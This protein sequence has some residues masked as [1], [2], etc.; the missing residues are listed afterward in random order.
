MPSV[1]KRTRSFW[2][3]GALIMLAGLALRLWQLGRASLWYDEVITELYAQASWDR[4]FTQVLEIGNHTPLYFILMRFFPTDNEFWLR[5]PSVMLGVIGVALLIYCS[6]RLYADER[7]ALLAGGLLAFNPY[8][9][10]LSRTARPYPL[11]FVFSLLASYYF[12][13]LLRGERTR[14]NWIAFTLCSMIAYVTHYFAVGLP[15]AQYVLFA[16]ILRG[17]RGFFR[18]WLWAQVIAGIPLL[19]WIIALLQQDQVAFGIG[20]IPRPRVTAIPV[21][22]WN[23][24]LGYDGSFPWYLPVGLAAAAVGL[25]YGIMLAVRERKKDRQN[26]YWFWLLV[27]PLS[28]GFVVSIIRPLYVDRYFTVFLPSVILL[29]AHGWN[30]LPLRLY[31]RIG[32]AVVVMVV[33][34]VSVVTTLEREDDEKEDWR[35]AAAFIESEQ[36]PEDALLLE[37]PIVILLV[38]RYWDTG[39]M[40][41]TWLE[42]GSLVV[43]QFKTPV[44]RV[45]ALYRNP[46]EDGHQQG[47]LP[48]F[49]PFEPSNSPLSDWLIAR[50]D[51]VIMQK[52]LNGIT[53]LLVDMSGELAG[54]AN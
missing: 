54:A 13:L 6:V 37:E 52:E 27:A 46:N 2:W 41:Y 23:M 35:S 50:R 5:L 29:A 19:I 22:L 21:T 16:F 8:H 28:L 48:D 26:F 30:H 14:K 3:I 17:N 47:V 20:W 9:I 45:W 36:Q 7:L 53:L 39:D 4:F 38:R 24:L 12:L 40:P 25:G 33:G 32:L 15:L 51:Q 31:W 34:S 43:E 18:R 42:G 1:S 10:W 11:L 44:S 49:D